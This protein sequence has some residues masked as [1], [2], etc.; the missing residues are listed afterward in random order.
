MDLRILILSALVA[1]ASAA[2]M[3]SSQCARQCDGVQP[4]ES[5]KTY[6]YSYSIETSSFVNDSNTQDQPSDASVLKIQCNVELV[7]Q[8]S[9]EVF[10]RVKDVNVRER[11]SSGQE[12]TSPKK[13]EIKNALEAHWLR[14]AFQNGVVKEVCP[15]DGE[16]K[17]TLNIKR[18]ILSAF[19]SP[20]PQIPQDVTQPMMNLETDVTGSC[21]VY[22]S[23]SMTGGIIKHK[24]FEG[25]K[26]RTLLEGS[27]QAMKLSPYAPVYNVMESMQHCEHSIRSPFIVASSSCK[28]SHKVRPFSKHNTGVVTVVT[29]ELSF[30]EQRNGGSPPSGYRQER[31]T[32]IVFEHQEMEKQPDAREAKNML[33]SYCQSYS[34]DDKQM[35][36]PE[37]FSKLIE[38]LDS[39]DDTGFQSVRQYATDAMTCRGKSE[40]LKKF[41]IDAVAMCESTA[42]INGMVSMLSQ[43][44]LVPSSVADLWVSSLPF[45]R[46]PTS[47][48][49]PTLMNLVKAE[50]IQ[51]LMYLSVSSLIHNFCTREGVDC[52]RDSNFQ[53]ALDHFEN[54][55][56]HDCS[57]S[58]EMT[59]NLRLKLIVSLKAI[60]NIGN[61]GDT[62]Y[63]S[64]TLTRC[65]QRTND[66][67]IRLAAIEAF[68]RLPCDEEERYEL[69]N[70]YKN[71]V[72]N[73]E[74][75]IA[76]YR[77]MMQCAS[78]DLLEVV[79]ETM[80]SEDD[81]QVGSF[82]MS[83]LK[84]LNETSDPQKQELKEVLRSSE[85]MRRFSRDIRKIS[86][87]YEVSWFNE[88]MM[89]GASFESNV[90]FSEKSFLPRS[91]SINATA[92]VFGYAINVFE[93]LIDTDQVSER[94]DR[95]T[96]PLPPEE[97]IKHLKDMVGNMQES[98]HNYKTQLQFQMIKADNRQ[99][100]ANNGYVG[101]IKTGTTPVRE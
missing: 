66:I 18:G 51:P 27:I 56:D 72:E 82:V 30:V 88:K 31:L 91:L 11:S 80:E 50:P 4:F 33:F 43:A 42:C 21:P 17:W 54:A 70:L 52:K 67:D 24:N 65:M 68:R 15:E 86:R 62:N 64:G 34:E 38:L 100:S 13:N 71:R 59:N 48:M 7:A 16:E 98:L 63:L 57:P 90:I 49:I 9:C 46:K 23:S 45:I 25:C 14:F 22:L 83:H 99:P 61:I 40:Q 41:F 47:E 97:E 75:R 84:N 60:G 1:A 73:T 89:T 69:T 28:E 92:E 77:A 101:S 26:D 12:I 5:Q 29:Q 8:S 95:G 74:L 58:G 20:I 94:G 10:L 96:S 93:D 32:N 85:V 37:Y 35:E 2:P 78:E 6:K 55:L 76:S 36:R 79:V 44:D 53:N 19:Q 39:I 3:S 81:D 87:N